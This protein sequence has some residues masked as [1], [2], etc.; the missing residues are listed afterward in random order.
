MFEISCKGDSY[1]LARVEGVNVQKII[2]PKLLG[3]HKEQEVYLMYG[4]F[5]YYLRHSNRNY[6]LPSWALDKC[7]C[8]V[9]AVK[10][11]EYKI[12]HPIK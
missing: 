11:I 8:F 12:N 2:E 6:S 3:I 10:I 9:D 5:G 4:K 7:V 1:G